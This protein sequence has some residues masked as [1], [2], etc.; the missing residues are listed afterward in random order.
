[1]V[2]VFGKAFGWVGRRFGVGSGTYSQ[3]VSNISIESVQTLSQVQPPKPSEWKEVVRDDQ[4]L[5]NPR[6]RIWEAELYEELERKRVLLLELLSQIAEHK[7]LK[8]Y[9]LE[10]SV[11]IAIW[12]LEG[13]VSSKE[14]VDA[15]DSFCI[16]PIDLNHFFEEDGKI[17]GYQGLKITIWV[18]SISFH[19][20]A[21]ITFQ[22]TFD[23][24]K[25][26][27]RSEIC[28]PVSIV[29]KGEILQQNTTNGHNSD[30]NSYL[31][32]DCSDLEGYS[33][34]GGHHACRAAIQS[35]GSN[36]I[37]ITDPRWEILLIVQKKIDLQGGNQLRLLGFAAIYRFYLYLDNLRLQL[38]Q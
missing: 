28:S 32:T 16:Q 3:C 8:V 21:D 26:D 5:I 33:G 1:M 29:L 25:G 15:P 11:S 22:S 9:G 2:G 37:D 20:Y 38:S 17:Y 27:Y 13:V 31:K 4:K 30:S 10:N 24:G 36:P 18:S 7:Q 34:C 12:F 14:E 6:E 23:G 19:A 35:I